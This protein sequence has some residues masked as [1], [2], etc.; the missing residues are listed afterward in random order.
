M[1]QSPA[2]HTVNAA[3]FSRERHKPN[4]VV[5]AGV[6][7]GMVAGGAMLAFLTANA[8]R[9][10]LPPLRPLALTAALFSGEGS[11]L[12]TESLVLAGLLWAAVSVALALLYAVLVP[13]D[14]PLVSAAM[15][16]I[17]YVFFVL[18]AM[19]SWV[20]PVLNPAMRAG[21]QRTGG[22][23]VLAYFVFGAA[24]GIIPALRR[25]IARASTA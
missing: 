17:G 9:A 4:D 24:L 16:G 14:F 8:S 25:R 22:A 10:D 18:V 19:T 5:S 7:G 3:D 13:R 12:G 6:T 1:A 2:E 21:I 11:R 20:L 23:W 15:V